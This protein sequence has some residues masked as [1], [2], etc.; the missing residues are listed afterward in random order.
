MPFALQIAIFV[1]FDLICFCP[2]S[3]AQF[4]CRLALFCSYTIPYYTTLYYMFY[5]LVV[6]F[7]AVFAGQSNQVNSGQRLL[8]KRD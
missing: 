8:Q 4:F 6:V 2:I 3:F 7:A 5:W 1:S